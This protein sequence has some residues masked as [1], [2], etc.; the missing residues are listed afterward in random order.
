MTKP[1]AIP[2]LSAGK[3][4]VYPTEGHRAA[5]NTLLS[6]GEI[7][8]SGGKFLRGGF[9]LRLSPLLAGASGS[10]KSTLVRGV[11]HKLEATY[12]KATRS[13]WIVQGSSHGRPTMFRVLDYVTT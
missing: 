9:R 5:A 3:E 2:P 11:S 13:D 4:S 1:C 7:F 10:G 8:Y 6:M 12:L